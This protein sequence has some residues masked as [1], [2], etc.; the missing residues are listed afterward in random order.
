MKHP[1]C[2][3]CHHQ[4]NDIDGWV[5][6]AKWEPRNVDG[7]CSAFWE[8]SRWTLPVFRRQFPQLTAVSNLGAETIAT[9]PFTTAPSNIDNMI[10]EKI[11]RDE[12][13]IWHAVR[14]LL[15]RGVSPDEI[16]ANVSD[17]MDIEKIKE[18]EN[19]ARNKPIQWTKH[20]QG[21]GIECF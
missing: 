12:R 11:A 10:T 1:Q 13:M 14:R 4:K 17:A 7:K 5:C 21:E 6:A 2:T 20:H 15:K 3:K 19:A 16:M 9:H 8:T 18:F